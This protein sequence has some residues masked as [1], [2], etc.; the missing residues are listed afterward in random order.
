MEGASLL[1]GSGPTFLEEEEE[2]E[3]EEEEDFSVH[4]WNK[5][6]LAPPPTGSCIYVSFLASLAIP[7]AAGVGEPGVLASLRGK[8]MQAGFFFRAISGGFNKSICFCGSV[9]ASTRVNIHADQLMLQA[10]TE[11]VPETNIQKPTEAKP[12]N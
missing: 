4:S 9:F 6:Q 2:D 10:T 12:F 5:C 7:H 3:E 1:L 11:P 8:A